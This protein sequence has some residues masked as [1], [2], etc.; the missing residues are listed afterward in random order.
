MLLY[1]GYNGGNHHSALTLLVHSAV[2]VSYCCRSYNQTC[3]IVA[4]MCVAITLLYRHCPRVRYVATHV[5]QHVNGGASSRQIK[6]GHKVVQPETI[7][8][9][10]MKSGILPRTCCHTFDTPA[11]IDI[12]QLIHVGSEL[13]SS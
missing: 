10:S 11:C 2:S 9:C 4:A 12:R 3:Y 5:V 7:I 6:R 8:A 1:N 13:V